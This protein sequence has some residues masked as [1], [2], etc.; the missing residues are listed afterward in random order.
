[1]VLIHGWLSSAGINWGLPGTIELLARSFRVI[2]LDVRGHGLWD[3]PTDPRAY[4]PEV[5]EDVA[6]LLDHLGI[7]N[8]QIVGYSLGGIIAANFLAKRLD[9]ALSG[10]LCGAGW[11]REGSVEQRIFGAGGKDRKPVGLCLQGLAQLANDSGPGCV[12]P[13]RGRP[14]HR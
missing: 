9:R 8:A 11:L 13:G 5:V 4:G 2:A 6:W 12:D 3:R 1:M 10:A 7:A 14:D